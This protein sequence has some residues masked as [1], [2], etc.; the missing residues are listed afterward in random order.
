MDSCSSVDRWRLARLDAVSKQR[1][2]L[3]RSAVA[4]SCID[5]GSN[6]PTEKGF[7]RG[8]YAPSLVPALPGFFWCPAA[9]RRRGLGERSGR[10]AFLE[11]ESIYTALFRPLGTTRPR[12]LENP[13]RPGQ[14]HRTRQ[15][16]GAPGHRTGYSAL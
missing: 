12:G 8:F 14:S 10:A 9:T 7:G 2:S 15:Q 3:Q 6:L 1:S 4:S 13:I 16:T 11:L 5:H